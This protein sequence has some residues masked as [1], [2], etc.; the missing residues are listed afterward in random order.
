MS[1]LIYRDMGIV[2]QRGVETKVLSIYET[3]PCYR[4]KKWPDYTDLYGRVKAHRVPFP[5][6]YHVLYLDHHF[7]QTS[8][9]S[10][11][12]YSGDDSLMIFCRN[13]PIENW[14]SELCIFPTETD[15]FSCTPHEHDGMRDE[16]LDRLCKEVLGIWYGMEDEMFETYWEKYSNY[17]LNQITKVDWNKLP[18][19]PA[20][21]LASNLDRRTLR[22]QVD[23]MTDSYFY[24]PPVPKTPFLR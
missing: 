2:G 3:A 23:W 20:S 14:D 10:N 12:E 19:Q 1:K 8:K 11:Y 18:N 9:L 5:Y 6:I 21:F 17:N 16:N 15:V 22:K 24:V 4:T 7:P 13:A